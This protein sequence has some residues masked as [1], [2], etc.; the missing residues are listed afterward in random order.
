MFS[1]RGWDARRLELGFL[2]GDPPLL[3]SSGLG[4]ARPTP[5]FLLFESFMPPARHTASLQASSAIDKIPAGPC[6]D[7]GQAI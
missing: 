6:S 3:L 4:R 2:S 5:H 1:S 7:N